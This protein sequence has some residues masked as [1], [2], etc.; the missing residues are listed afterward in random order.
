MAI[1]TKIIIALVLVL[2]LLIII[3]VPGEQSDGL[4]GNGNAGGGSGDSAQ[5]VQP[6][7]D[8][9]PVAVREWYFV[10]LTDVTGMSAEEGV[11]AAWGFDYGVK[12]INESGGVRGISVRSATR[13]TASVAVNAAAEMTAVAEGLGVDGGALLVL[14]PVLSDEYDA[15]AQI[16]TEAHI[17]AIGHAVGDATL[18][19]Y[20]PYAISSAAE[21]GGAAGKAVAAWIAGDPGIQKIAMIYNSSIYSINGNAERVK[22]VIA[23]EG[24]SLVGTVETG[25]DTFDAAGVAE[26]AM[27]FDADAYYIDLGGDGNRRVAEQLAHL[28]GDSAPRL[29]MGSLNVDL[30][31]FLDIAVLSSDKVFF[32]SEYDPVADGEKRQAFDTAFAA[33]IGSNHY[34]NIAVNYCQA[35]R[36]AQQAIEEL[37][38]TGDPEH[39][40]EERDKLAAYLRDCS[41]VR[42]PLGDYETSAG[43]KIAQSRLYRMKDGAFVSV[44]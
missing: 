10:M 41:L 7:G 32:W 15:A 38:L 19:N 5:S 6:P 39:L 33:A 24:L 14:G 9:P 20:A 42:T 40:T 27:G 13:D 12:A 25:G 26:T 17:P 2:I 22:E 35:A 43:R 29:I 21:P 31:Q 3:A 1:K 34:Y 11:A 18:Q 28:N 30:S 4:L 16:F 37:G 8:A 23:G 44:P 36:F